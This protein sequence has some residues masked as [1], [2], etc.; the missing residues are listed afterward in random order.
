MRP[1]PTHA[2]RWWPAGAVDRGTRLLVLV[3]AGVIWAA[4]GVAR[5]VVRADDGLVGEYFANSEL[6][7]QPAFSVVDRRPSTDAMRQR[8]DGVLPERF[9]VR[10]TGFITV[11]RAGLYTFA[12]AS[13]DGSELIVDNRVVVDNGGPHG[14]TTRT[15]A[16]QLDRGSHRVELRYVQFAAVSALDWSWADAGADF[17]PVPASALTQ[18]RTTYP[19]VVAGQL[20]EWG[21][22]IVAG[23]VVILAGWYIRAAVQREMVIRWVTT[24]AVPGAFFVAIMFTPWAVGGP[25]FRSVEN[26]F[27]V[28]NETAIKTVAGY[29]TF[30][31]NLDTPQ[32][33]EYVL[34]SR[35]EE[36]LAML[37]SHGLQEYRV[38]AAI[39]E[40]SWVLQQIVASGWPRKL[41]KDAKRTFVLNTEPALPGC[42]VI[43]RQREVS[44][45]YCP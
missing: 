35:V 32:T 22:A 40:N 27:R 33:G 30:R 21:F 2:R 18:R 14:L 38:S 10:W 26:T 16:I 25:F 13:D 28:L 19:R 11:G 20:V 39:A 8:W 1:Q 34:G 4:L 37:R 5:A 42:S 7:G 45:V 43:D 31:T 24:H 3:A 12:T 15:G 44:L 6:S 41:E 36:M 9:S 29:S 17:S 23:L